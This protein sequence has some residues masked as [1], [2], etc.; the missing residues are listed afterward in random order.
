MALWTAKNNILLR[1][2]EEGKTLREAKEGE[3]RAS[4]LLPITL[5][6]DTSADLE[7]ISG[8][9]PPGLQLKQNKI[10]DYELSLIF[11]YF[12][13][14]QLDLV[15]S[16]PIFIILKFLDKKFVT[17]HKVINDF[18]TSFI[19]KHIFLKIIIN[20]KNTYEDEKYW[21]QSFLNQR[22]Y[23]KNSL[24]RFKSFFN[25]TLTDVN[26]FTKFVSQ[27]KI[28]NPELNCIIL[29]S[30]IDS[31][32]L[33]GINFFTSNNIR[34]INVSEYEKLEIKYKIKYISYYYLKVIK[35]IT[36]LINIYDLLISYDNRL[37]E[38]INPKPLYINFLDIY[39][40][41]DT[42][43]INMILSN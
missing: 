21:K 42:E 39:S 41:N 3:T 16:Y 8:S 22:E 26:G 9:L 6:V 20:Y 35:T 12:L 28:N 38:I 25:S 23:L 7:V 10:Q 27:L 36:Y 37:K 31:V 29:N 17:S 4:E 14:N 32:K 15:E 34:L 40:D 13:K 18:Y 33:L 2:I 30:L 19:R 5:D 24:L 43:D 11:R 1:S